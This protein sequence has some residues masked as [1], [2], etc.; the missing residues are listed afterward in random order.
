MSVLEYKKNI[1]SQNGED[2]IIEYIFN[3][4]NIKNGNFIEFGAWDGIHLSNT[5]NLFNKGWGGIYIE[6]DTSKYQSLKNNF[7]NY[8][9]RITCLNKM[10]GYEEKDNLDNIIDESNYRIKEFDFISIDVDG[11][12]FYIF[13]AMK[14][15]LPKVICIEVNAGHSPLYDTVID[16]DIAKNNIG[17]SM[18]IISKEAEKKGYFP[19]CYTGNF[20]LIQNEFKNLFINDIKDLTNIYIDFLKYLECTNPG[21]LKHL[22]NTF[23]IEKNYN[24]MIF[25]NKI[26]S[27]YFI[28]LPNKDCL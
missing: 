1:H 19:L 3:T 7:A 13:K 15:Y 17:Q 11:L 21:G 26:L 6:A 2:G 24:N 27:N 23:I 12:D 9:D 25:E 4:L 28:Q 16:I 22:Y 18:T 5:Y 10:V 20:F 14:K 8:T